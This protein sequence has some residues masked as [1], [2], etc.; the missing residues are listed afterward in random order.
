VFTGILVLSSVADESSLRRQPPI[1]VNIGVYNIKDITVVSDARFLATCALSGL[2]KLLLVDSEVKKNVAEIQLP[3]HTPQRICMIDD[4]TAVV[5]LGNNKQILFVNIKDDVLVLGKLL[6]V[7]G[8]VF[9]IAAHANRLVVS[10]NNPPRIEMMSRNG[11]VLHCLDNHTAG[12]DVMKDPHF[13]AS[14]DYGMLYVTDWELATVTLLDSTL[15]VVRTFTDPL[16]QGPCGIVSVSSKEVLVNSWGNSKI[17]LL[18]P[19]TGTCTSILQE[20]DGIQKPYALGYSKSQKK[21]FVQ[22]DNTGNI[23]VF[24]H[25]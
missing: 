25:T 2:G 8:N 17:L 24:K 22:G 18:C 5:S 14:S 23:Q 7:N 20:R 15:R 6:S 13:I 16:L 21:V 9:G 1:D 4:T 10:Y 12:R 19:S 3:G 11:N